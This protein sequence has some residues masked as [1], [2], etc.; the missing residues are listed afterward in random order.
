MPQQRR[1]NHQRPADLQR[2]RGDQR[3]V[4]DQ[5]EGGTA[6]GSDDREPE[7]TGEQQEYPDGVAEHDRCEPLR[8]VDPPARAGQQRGA[9]QAEDGDPGA[10]G[11]Q[12]VGSAQRQ[13]RPGGTAAEQPDTEYGRADAGQRG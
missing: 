8:R 13:L 11:H 5:P 1:L 9:G 4:Q 7:Q 12:V 2:A 6:L 3:A 10:G